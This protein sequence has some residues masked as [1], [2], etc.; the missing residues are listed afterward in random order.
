[1]ELPPLMLAVE[2]VPL[3][4][5]W[6]KSQASNVPTGWQVCLIQH[7]SFHT[8]TM[9]AWTGTGVGKPQEKEVSSAMY[10]AGANGPGG[11]GTGK[12]Q[13][14]RFRLFQ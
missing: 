13:C 10:G 1:M 7:R 14:D 6:C 5:L 2:G 3:L 12:A 4:F 9:G 8:T 11:D